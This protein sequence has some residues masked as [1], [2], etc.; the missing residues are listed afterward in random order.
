VD[1]AQ[2]GCGN[3]RANYFDPVSIGGVMRALAVGVVEEPR[4]PKAAVR[5]RY[6][7]WVG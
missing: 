6:S 4:H 2:G 1:P 7:G 3:A 5:V